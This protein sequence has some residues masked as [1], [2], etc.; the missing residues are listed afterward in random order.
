M[1]L[2]YCMKEGE[3]NV[4]MIQG[5]GMCGWLEGMIPFLFIRRG[6]RAADILAV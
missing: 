2:G 3:G 6:L 1:I 5:D 4:L